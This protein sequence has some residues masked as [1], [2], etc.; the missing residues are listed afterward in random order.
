MPSL[1]LI[2]GLHAHQPPRA[3]ADEGAAEFDGGY[4]FVDIAPVEQIVGEDRDPPFLAFEA[5]AQIEHAEGLA[6]RDIEL[7]IA[8]EGGERQRQIGSSP[9]NRVGRVWFWTVWNQVGPVRR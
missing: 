4:D 6:V 5:G 3:G 9:L 7:A 1:E 2:P 8:D